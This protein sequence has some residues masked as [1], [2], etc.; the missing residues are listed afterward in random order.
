MVQTRSQAAP[1][2]IGDAGKRAG[3][4]LQPD[5]DLRAGAA[6]AGALSSWVPLAMR[7]ERIHDV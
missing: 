4:A 5:V 1:P 3:A 7:N 6:T 2:T